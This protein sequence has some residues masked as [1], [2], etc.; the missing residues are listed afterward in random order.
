MKNKKLL[1]ISVGA[2]AYNEEQNIVNMLKS[3]VSQKEKT[4]KIVEIIVISEAYA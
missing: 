2:A 4:V 1:N 3:V